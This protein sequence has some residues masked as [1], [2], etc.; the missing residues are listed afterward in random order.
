M[1]DRQAEIA[2]FWQTCCEAHGIAPDT[3]YY[4]GPFSDPALAPYQEMLLDL[5]RVGKK[6]ATARLE[7][8]FARDGIARRS[9]DDLWVVL[10]TAGAPACLVRIT[11][12]HIWAFEDVPLDFA[13]REGE[14]D[15]SLEYWSRVH[16]E[17][18]VQQ[19]ERWGLTW[20]DRLAVVCEGFDVVA[21][22]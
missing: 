10:D 16:K 1:T 5:V 20:S 13:Q 14:G 7:Q 15:N 12:I 21:M 11:D 18:F 3:P 6:R 4:A 22:R 2:T 19:C 9:P 17:Y 8:E